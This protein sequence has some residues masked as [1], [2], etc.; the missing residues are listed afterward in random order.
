MY[1]DPC[2]F[3]LLFIISPWCLVINLSYLLAW[4]LSLSLPSLWSD[5]KFPVLMS[6]FSLLF[7][8]LI[9]NFYIIQIDYPIHLVTLFSVF[10]SFQIPAF[11]LLNILYLFFTWCLNVLWGCHTIKPD[12]Q[13]WCSFNKCLHPKAGEVILQT[14][15]RLMR[16]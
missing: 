16:R 12:S 7:N 2:V 1:V 3:Y 5:F 11:I 13:K 4:F 14:L 9:V 15:T 6:L 10:V 8:L